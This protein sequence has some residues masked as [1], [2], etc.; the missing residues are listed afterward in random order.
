MIMADTEGIKEP[1]LDIEVG[2]TKLTLYMEQSVSSSIPAVWI[3]SSQGD[4]AVAYNRSETISGQNV[5]YAPPTDEE[6]IA[7]DLPTDITFHV[8]TNEDQA[9]A[10]AEQGLEGS[11]IS[12]YIAIH[13]GGWYGVSEGSR[14]TP[15]IYLDS[16]NF[17][18][19]PSS[20]SHGIYQNGKAITPKIKGMDISRV[21]YNGKQIYPT[22]TF[23]PY[24]LQNVP[25]GVYIIDTGN[26]LYPRANWDTANNANAMG[27]A[28]ISDNCRFAISK[29]QGGDMVWDDT[30]NSDVLINDVV[31]TEDLNTAKLDYDGEG[32]T[33]KIIAQLGAENAPAA[34]YCRNTSGLFPNNKQ[35]YLP[36]LGEWNE[37]YNNKAEIDTCMSLIGGDAINTTYYHWTSTQVSASLS[38]V[39]RWSGRAMGS[40]SKDYPYPVRAFLSLKTSYTLDEAPNGV[41]VLST[42]NMLYKKEGW[43]AANNA[44]AVGVAVLSDDCR[45]VISKQEASGGMIWGSTGTPSGCFMNTDKSAALQDFAGKANTDAVITAY[46]ENANAAYYCRNTE[47]L[48]PDG[49]KGYLPSSGEWKAVYDNKSEVVACMSLIGGTSFKNDYYWSSSLADLY[50][51]WLLDWTNGNVNY[52]ARGYYNY[53]VRAVASLDPASYTPETA[54]NG[55]YIC[56]NEGKL[57]PKADWNQDNNDNSVGVAIVT[58]NVRLLIKKGIEAKSNIPW[59][60]ALDGVDLPEISNGDNAD[61]NGMNN[62][63]A[64]RQAAPSEN[65]T[66]NAAWYCYSQTISVNSKNIN[67]YLPAIGELLDIYGNKSDIEDALTLIGSQTITE[68]CGFG[69][70]LYLYSSSEASASYMTM[71]YWNDGS[72]IDAPKGGSG[73][74]TSILPIFP[75]SLPLNIYTPETAPNGV[76]V[77]S[78]DGKL[79]KQDVW[80]TANNDNAVGVG[81]VA[82]ECKFVISKQEASNAMIWGSTGT[83]AGCF[84]SNFESAALQ[85]FAGEANTDAVIAAYGENANAAYYCWNAEGL[86]PDGRQGYLPSFGELRTAYDNKSEVVAC[87][88]LIGG[89]AFRNSYYW[90]SSLYDPNYAWLMSWVDSSDINDGRDYFMGYVRA[91]TSMS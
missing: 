81:V 25:N 67:G 83:P 3:N 13:G 73:G 9:R 79:Y 52:G 53:C 48:F 70:D 43:D 21:M 36:S 60:S 17:E 54:P 11:A 66:N 56:T 64:I 61:Y 7:F 68:S 27:V 77:Y 29:V 18:E 41:Y 34:N 86:F 46:G 72:S 78:T 75:L 32:N 42:D 45:F 57:Y 84:M 2:K 82:D 10:V 58:D 26:L 4:I 1:R 30:E 80:D 49:R 88:S 15:A 39:L 37:A 44:N 91:F 90:S 69:N 33:N 63:A 22:V 47:G 62:S 38:W 16:S 65:D 76:Y 40:G 74:N 28:V 20:I 85:D 14:T 35:G 89:A 24:T 8:F 87:M 19:I 5:E 71:L 59:S 12:N 50:N 23:E 31:T 6:R 51:A 55:V